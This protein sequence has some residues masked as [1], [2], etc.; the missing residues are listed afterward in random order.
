M[1]DLYLGIIKQSVQN[2]RMPQNTVL[3]DSTAMLNFLRD[4]YNYTNSVADISI[5]TRS[6]EFQSYGVVGAPG[7]ET[8]VD[9]VWNSSHMSAFLAKMI[10][11]QTGFIINGAASLFPFAEVVN[12][13]YTAN[14]TT[15]GL[16]VNHLD[17]SP[18]SNVTTLSWDQVRNNMPKV[19][20]VSCH[21]NVVVDYDVLDS[22]LGS[23]NAGGI[24]LLAN[25]SNGSEMYHSENTFPEEVH[26]RILATND[27]YSFHM[28][29]YVSYTC[30]IKK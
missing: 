18:I 2:L 10:N 15:L 22:L 28:Q 11:A 3:P 9:M 12:S 26:N 17:T 30:F 4:L 14:T 13:V 6:I 19:D 20:I 27:F 23:V 16:T 24:F 21:L 8:L 25:A 29:G 1:P 7:G 5:M